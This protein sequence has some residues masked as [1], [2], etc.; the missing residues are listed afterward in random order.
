MHPSI[1]LS[2]PSSGILVL[3]L[4]Y[5]GLDDACECFVSVVNCA[6]HA[7]LVPFEVRRAS[8]TGVT[9]G[10][11]PGGITI[12]VSVWVSALH[13]CMYSSTRGS[14]NRASDTHGG[15]NKVLLAA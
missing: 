2:N 4:F 10:C 12:C 13:T 8:G 3:F 5:T 15:S 7:C 1:P 14:L 11:V 6:L 9:D